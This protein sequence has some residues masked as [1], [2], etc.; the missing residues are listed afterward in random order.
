MTKDPM[1]LMTPDAQKILFERM[2][3]VCNG[4]SAE[5]VAGAAANILI[6]AIRQSQP[7]REKASSRFDELFTNMKTVLMNHYDSFGRLKGI[8]PYPQEIKVE[9]FKHKNFN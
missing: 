3:E 5:Q 7:S 8:F 9:H 6:N 1:I 4:F 2:S